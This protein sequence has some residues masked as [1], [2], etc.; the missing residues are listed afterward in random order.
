L[1]TAGKRELVRDNTVVVVVRDTGDHQLEDTDYF[2]V[3]N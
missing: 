1:R 2:R 3:D